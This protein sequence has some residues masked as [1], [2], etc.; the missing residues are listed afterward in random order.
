MTDTRPVADSMEAARSAPIPLVLDLDG[1]LIATD[2]LA[3]T[4]LLFLKAQPLRVFAVLVWLLR[5]KAHLKRRLAQAVSLD[6]A[7]LPVRETVVDLALAAAAEGRPVYL[8]TA[9]DEA[10]VAPLSA[11]LPFLSGVIGSDGAVNLKGALK[12]QALAERFPDGF[13]YVGDSTADLPVWRRARRAIY[14]GA[15]AALAK[16]LRGEKAEA[17][18]LAVE[19]PTPR[20][21]A[22]ALRLHQWSKNAL[23]FVPIVLGGKALDLQAWSACLLGF[24]AMGLLASAT[25]VLNDLL[26]LAEDRAH[27]T[28]RN[29]AFASGKISLWTGLA[30]V[31]LG[32]VGGAVLGA[33]AGWAAL[34]GL[35]AYLALTVLYSFRL[36]REPIVDI[37]TLGGLFTLRLAIGVLCA[38]V[39][40]SA[41]LLVF[42]MFVFTSLSFAKRFT[43][44]ERLA[45]RGGE[46]SAGRG[47]VARD[48]PMVLA[49]GVS[50]SSA[51]VLVMVM[52]LI[53]EA[54][55]AKYYGLPQ[56]LWVLPIVLAL[57]LGRVWLLCGR[58]ELND[59]PVAF[60]VRDRVSLVLGGVI[61]LALLAA[62]VLRPAA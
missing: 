15:S 52:Y 45:A 26:D 50:L 60:A 20:V 34:G 53:E 61:G 17:E 41:W 32:L 13:D 22:K 46:R 14:V 54:F 40:W 18:V 38:D 51:A 19:R 43:E 36:K 48:R 24:L 47:Y 59:D 21:W 35:G 62:L 16:A 37:A 12:A 56:A 27:W 3:E 25:Y 58:G 8:A 49:L 30:L 9:S 39:A 44:L 55:R 6:V 33:L 29:R 10:L 23:L 7:G 4:L 2:L 42:S 31:P 5:G 28:K 57:W 1:T 11:R